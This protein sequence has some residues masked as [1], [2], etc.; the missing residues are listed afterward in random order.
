MAETKTDATK[1]AATDIGPTIVI[2]GKLKSQEDLVVRG[3][4]EA[5][6]SSTQAFL[7]ET[8]GVVRANVHAQSA[9]IRGVVVGNVAAEQKIEIAAEGRMVGDVRAPRV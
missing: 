1:S 2:R 8:S 6:V 3:R 5:E 9:K 7:V 4:I